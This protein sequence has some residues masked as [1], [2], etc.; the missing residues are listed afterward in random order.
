MTKTLQFRAEAPLI[1]YHQNSSNSCFLSSLAS[2]FHC[3][4]DNRAVTALVNRIEESCTLQKDIFK[5]R[6]HS[7]NAI[8]KNRRKIKGEQNLQYN[9]KIRKKNDG[10][11]I[12]NDISE[13]ITLLQLKESLGNVNNDI[14]VVGHWILDSNYKKALCLTQESLDIILELI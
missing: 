12:L 10:F 4:G 8:M 11:D 3:I 7:S 9:L 1:K 14:S 5:S 2:D 6:M 13:D